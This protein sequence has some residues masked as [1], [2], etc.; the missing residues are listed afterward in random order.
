M[1]YILLVFK[2]PF[3][4]MTPGSSVV[5]AATGPRIAPGFRQDSF[6]FRGQY[7]EYQ[8]YLGILTPVVPSQLDLTHTCNIWHL[9]VHGQESGVRL[10]RPL[11]F[12]DCST[13]KFNLQFIFN[14][15]DDKRLDVLEKL[16]T[17]LLADVLHKKAE[18]FA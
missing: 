12:M 14:L 3:L 13:A 1:Q 7:K 8:D 17:R 9:R 16:L 6:E 2:Y 10:S 4:T 11:F 15:V 18:M 5:S